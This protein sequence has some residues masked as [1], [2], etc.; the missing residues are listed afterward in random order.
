[1]NLSD[2]LHWASKVAL[3]NIFISLAFTAGWTILYLI[4]RKYGS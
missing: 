1:M 2:F 4:T 3:A